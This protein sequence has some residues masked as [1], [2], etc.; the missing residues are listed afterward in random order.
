MNQ[1]IPNNLGTYLFSFGCI[2][3]THI[4]EEE[5]KSA[6]PYICNALANPRAR[7][8]VN[9][10][11]AENCEFIVHLGDIINPVPHLETYTKAVEKSRVIFSES[12][13]PM[14]F[15]PGN[16]DVG[17]K[18]LDW[19]PA[20]NISAESL[21]QYEQ[22]VGEHYFFLSRGDVHFLFLNA[23]VFNSLF[24]TDLAQ[25]KW[26]KEE[27]AL[28][29]SRGRRIFLFLHYPPF[30]THP[31]EL[32][33][34]DNLDEPDRS[35]LLNLCTE[36]EVEAIFAG[37][38]HN[39][40][41]N[42]YKGTD[43]YTLPSTSFFRLD[44]TEMFREKPGP[45]DEYG[46]NDAGKMGVGVV[47][48]YEKGHVFHWRRT[49]GR[50]LSPGEPLSI[51][52]TLSTGETLPDRRKLRL[53]HSMEGSPVP[54]GLD[55]KHPWTEQVWIPA[56]GALEEF[57]R[58][59]VRND[60]GLFAVW[61]MGLNRLR[62]PLQDI[63]LETNRERVEAV[64]T[65]GCAFI[66]YCYGIPEGEQGEILAQYGHL[67]D[68]LELVLKPNRLQLN[69][70]ADTLAALAQFKEGVQVP[71]FLSI[72]RGV[73]EFGEATSFK[74]IVDHGFQGDE[75]ER[76][77][78]LVSLPGLKEIFQ[79]LY[80]R[81]NADEPILERMMIIDSI[82]REA[83]L[84]AH[85]QI[86]FAGNSLREVKTD[87]DEMVRRASEAMAASFCCT[88]CTIFF[89][90]FID[91]DRSYFVRTGFYDRLYNPKRPA[92]IVR[93]LVSFFKVHPPEGVKRIR[94]S[95]DS[96][97]LEL[98]FAEGEKGFLLENSEEVSLPELTGKN[99]GPVE[100]LDL[101]GGTWES[102]SLSENTVFS[103]SSGN[104]HFSEKG[105]FL[106]LLPS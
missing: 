20:G 67:L 55:L 70:I 5:D 19:M 52:E 27:M 59:L 13:A 46:R 85:V 38:V 69:R 65:K 41:Y 53:F 11:N 87:E 92:M 25:K 26:L 79:G 105:Y 36:Y 18:P 61:E 31:E 21:D 50:T 16:H 8:A 96:W 97:G 57:D 102:I 75:K 4:N 17:D 60:Y 91:V 83:D 10:L 32:S 84:Y 72:L 89:D 74:H 100:Y 34:Y 30:I 44:Y 94:P 98:S 1:Q 23:E 7:Y 43:I 48:L 73:N 68:S 24:L 2:T 54:V 99:Q 95:A 47:H 78:A 104:V 63:T 62:V 76:I 6:S 56:N 103:G 86:R 35:F 45:E 90:T 15:I 29:R 22:L 80:F 101:T 3:D 88:H 39:L 14:Y 66:G 37:H 51:G 82:A 64:G 106:L 58:K 77:H 33:S 81:I 40:G 93:H 42:R 9:L 49:M 12:K 28:A 71:L